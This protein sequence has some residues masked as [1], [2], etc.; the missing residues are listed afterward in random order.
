MEL[1]MDYFKDRVLLY[2]IDEGKKSFAVTA[3]VPQG[4]VL[5]P[6]LW[7]AMYAVMGTHKY[8]DLWT[9]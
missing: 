2:D 4:S 6:I 5:G 7:N 1:L 8:S 3:G 9:I